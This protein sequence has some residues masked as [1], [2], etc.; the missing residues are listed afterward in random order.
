MVTAACQL[1]LDI[2]ANDGLFFGEI[3]RDPAKTDSPLPFPDS[4]MLLMWINGS[5]WA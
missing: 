5:W 1:A 2:K 4:G 3:Y